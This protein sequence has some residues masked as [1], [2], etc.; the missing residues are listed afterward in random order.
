MWI[1]RRIGLCLVLLLALGVALGAHT[2]WFKPLRLSWFYDRVFFQELLRSPMTLSSLRLLDGSGLAWY[3]D[4]WDDFSPAA[5]DAEQARLHASEA[6]F[7]SYDPSALKGVDK[8]SWQVADYQYKE[9]LAQEKWRWVGYPVNPLF[10]LQ[11]Y[12]PSFLMNTHTVQSEADARDYIRRLQGLAPAFTQ[13]LDDMR[14][15]DQKGW[16]PQRFAVDKT[17]AQMRDFIQPAP[18]QHPLVLSLQT[19]LRALP[20]LKPETVDALTAQAKQAVEQQVYPAYRQLIA[21]FEILARK[22]LNNDGAWHWRDGDAYY[23]DAIRRHT[24]TRYSAEQIHQTGLQEVARIGK[25]IDA[26]LATQELP[27]G[28]R[29]EKIKAL[30]ARPEQRYP[31]TDAGRDAI[32]RDYQAIIDEA[33]AKLGLYFGMRP[34]TRVEVRRVPAFA[35][36]TAPGG[37]YEMPSLDGSRPGM[38]F[39][40]LAKVEGT[41]KFSMR[42]LAYHEAIPG[43]HFQIALQM[44]MEGLP[45]FR[46]ASS[47]T[48]YVEG[49]ALYA[50]RLAWEIGL[51][52]AP[53]DN[54]G[55]LQAEMFRAVRL[56]VDTGLHAKRWTREQAIAYMVQ[57]TGMSENEVTIEIERYLVDPGQA[58]AYKTGMMKILELREWSRQQLGNTFKLSEFHDVVLGTGAVPLDVL[59][60]V[61]RDWVASR[62]V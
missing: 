29:A 1:L 12:L 39:A 34:Q 18:A 13:A 37:Y 4:R 36:K 19:S 28:S 27:E 2:W 33:N 14:Q 49:W 56:V 57:E 58:L 31:D 44:K 16:Q 42:S 47:F 61:V 3:S 48:A 46:R 53:L 5:K 62:K 11:S 7:R 30:A 50:E 22:D 17:L 8:V 23:A 52:A 41:P 6:I 24:T 45:F 21:H 9:Q 10:G 51:E 35:E 15:R 20:K 43:H 32:L 25:E 55:R 54:L 60:S 26:I 38:F 59:E 40:N